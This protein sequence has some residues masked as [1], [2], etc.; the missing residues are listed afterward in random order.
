MEIARASCATNRFLCPALSP[1]ESA[2]SRRMSS[3][4]STAR[5]TAELDDV[6]ANWQTVK[7]GLTLD[8]EPEATN[9]REPKIK[10]TA[11]ILKAQQSFMALRGMEKRSLNRRILEGEKMLAEKANDRLDLVSVIREVM[12]QSALS[13][14][15]EENL[16]G[17]Q[18]RFRP[19]PT[20]NRQKIEQP[21]SPT[22][23]SSGA[24][25]LPPLPPS[26]SKV[27]QP[28]CSDPEDVDSPSRRIWAHIARGKVPYA[29][30]INDQTQ[31]QELVA[32]GDRQYQQMVDQFFAR[33]DEAWGRLD[34]ILLEPATPDFPSAVSD[35]PAGGM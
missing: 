33:E 30:L 15:Q 21:V 5:S 34:S 24:E 23:R 20:L 13:K 32:A 19:K 26:P 14:T 8:P 31:A 12:A 3:V 6:F 10:T 29:N 2:V 35:F 25:P 22:S 28:A 9:G 27:C 1:L 16:N 17:R 11:A 4:P 18:A 7:E